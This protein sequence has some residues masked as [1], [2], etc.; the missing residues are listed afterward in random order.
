MSISDPIADMFTRIRN[1]QAARKVSVDMPASKLKGAIAQV[2]K[3]EGFI[4][5]YEIGTEAG[6]VRLHIELKYFRGRP[7]IEMI[8]RISKP[9]RRVYRGKDELPRVLGGLGVVILSTSAGVMTD[10]AARA[11]GQGGEIMAYVA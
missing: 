2:L 9:S 10:R 5:D 1:A 4:K 7:V 6:K 3:D 8:E 11:A